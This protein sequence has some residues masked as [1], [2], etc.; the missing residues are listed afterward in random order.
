M[1]EPATAP[2]PELE[3]SPLVARLR[4]LHCGGEL[5]ITSLEPGGHSDLGP[6]GRL[7]CSRC[8]ED[9]PVVAGTPRLLQPGMLAEDAIKQRTA[10]SFAYEWEQFGDLRPEW[11]KNFLDYMQP[12]GADFFDG[13]LV[14]D[15]GAGSGRHSHQAAQLGAD[16]VAVDVGGS[17]DVARRNLP[18]RVLTVQADAETLPFE[19][20]SFDFVMSIGVLHHLPDTERAL[21]SVVRYA[22]PGG[23][24]QIY[25]YW[26]PEPRWQQRV[27]QWVAALRRVT[28]RMPR[29]LLHAFCY[30]LAVALFVVAV[31]PHRILRR[32]A[33]G[34]AIASHIPLRGYADYPFGVLVNDQFDRFSAPL[35][36][37]FTREEVHRM[38]AASGLEQIRVIANNGWI[39]SAIRSGKP[40]R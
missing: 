27:L 12:H 25:L 6:D 28:V 3:I 32:T 36:R 23:G 16:V 13:L 37:R 19:E 31:V 24:V 40:V 38:L 20:G 18:A 1:P 5:G 17:I 29:R 8:G 33:R 4:C 7:E 22:K 21:S 14:L 34:H 10:E 9:Y 30:P 26:L 11:R 39:G 15:V 2:L 35:E